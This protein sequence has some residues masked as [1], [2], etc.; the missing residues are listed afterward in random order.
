MSYIFNMLIC[1]GM[2]LLDNLLQ[3]FLFIAMIDLSRTCGTATSLIYYALVMFMIYFWIKIKSKVL[4]YLSKHSICHDYQTKREGGERCFTPEK[5]WVLTTHL[6][7]TRQSSNWP[8]TAL[9]VCSTVFPVPSD[10]NVF[11]AY[12]LIV[13]ISCT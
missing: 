7:S 13:Y 5:R 4:I 1:V 9:T 2:I 10:W 8:S 11:C 12:K 3:C 6:W